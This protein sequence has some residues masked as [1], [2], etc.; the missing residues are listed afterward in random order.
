MLNIF[1]YLQPSN[2]LY[3]SLSTSQLTASSYIRCDDPTDGVFFNQKKDQKKS[4][5][6]KICLQSSEGT[7]TIR[8]KSKA[9]S[10]D[11]L[12]A[13]EGIYQAKIVDNHL[14]CLKNIFYPGIEDTSHQQQ[15]QFK[16]A[17]FPYAFLRSSKLSALPEEGGKDIMNNV[18]PSI[19]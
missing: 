1:F 12:A 15:V 6:S 5:G 7:N 2:P 17:N 9:S 11:D 14:Q 18:E 16:R 10:C 13:G 19:Y 4:E 8:R 3:R